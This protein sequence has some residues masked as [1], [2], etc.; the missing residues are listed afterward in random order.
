M[1]QHFIRRLRKISMFEV[2][3]WKN[4]TLTLQL[5]ILHTQKGLLFARLYGELCEYLQ[6]LEQLQVRSL[7]GLVLLI[8]RPFQTMSEFELVLPSLSMGCTFQ[9]EAVKQCDTKKNWYPKSRLLLAG[10]SHRQQ[11]ASIVQSCSQ[12]VQFLRMQTSMGSYQNASVGCIEDEDNFS[13]MQTLLLSRT[14][15]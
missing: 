6:W 15:M 5:Y 12:Y 3:P 8:S 14:D 7:A 11:V 10:S 1:R 13:N 4:V 2:S 9:T